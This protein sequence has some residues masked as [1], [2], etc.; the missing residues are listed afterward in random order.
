MIIAR[1]TY[2]AAWQEKHKWAVLLSIHK[3]S[4]TQ[5]GLFDEVQQLSFLI[6]C[7]QHLK[8][9]LSCY[10]RGLTC[11]PC[12]DLQLQMFSRYLGLSRSV[13]AAFGC[14]FLP[15]NEGSIYGT[16][17]ACQLM[18]NQ[19]RKQHF[20]PRWRMTV[21]TQSCV[22]D[23]KNSKPEFY[24]QNKDKPHAGWIPLYSWTRW[25]QIIYKCNWLQ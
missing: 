13:T 4:N 11:Y 12:S 18:W 23:W 22:W 3:G 25:R 14:D 20:S 7:G 6:S 1:K 10:R 5:S 24:E 21:T 17:E 15:K 19:S 9:L 8:E 2:R 16:M